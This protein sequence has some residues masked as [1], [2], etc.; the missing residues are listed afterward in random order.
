MTTT[1][2]EPSPHA[3]STDLLIPGRGQPVP[4][5]TVVIKGA[6]IIWVGSS[7]KLPSTYAKVPTKNVPYLVAGL[8][9]CHLHFV[10]VTSLTTG[11]YFATTPVHTGLR[12]ARDAAATL[13]AGFTSVRDVG[14]FG[15]EVAKAVHEGT[16][17]GPNVYSSGSAI[18]MTGG[19]TDK[20]SIPLPV[21]QC[22]NAQGSPAELADGPD[23]AMRAVRLQL[24]KG[25]RL[26]KIC[27]TG[28]AGSMLDDPRHRQFSDAELRAFVEEA[29]RAQLIVASHCHGREGILACIAAGVRTIEHGSYLDEEVIARMKEKDV[30]LVP[31][32]SVFVAGL[33]LAELWEPESYAKLK[34]MAGA[35]EHSYALAV[36]R[37]VKIA[38]GTDLNMSND[39][40]LGHGRNGKE[41]SYAVQA[42]MTPLQAIEACTATAPETLGPQAPLSGQVKEGYDADLIALEENPL[43]DIELLAD[44][45]NIKYVWKGGRVVKSPS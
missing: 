41:L 17:E 39:S 10:G 22:V 23:S 30:I 5:A 3:I 36:R 43:E 38:L 37:G 29:S 18:G 31:T 45:R 15:C 40:L 19:H 4:S 16:I 44:P 34:A 25:A 8:W 9:D 21:V 27:G 32:R 12:L 42:G 6:K 20:H 1:P 14:G 24:R 2:S 7:A 26:I 33:K 28:G 13:K 35:H 11:A